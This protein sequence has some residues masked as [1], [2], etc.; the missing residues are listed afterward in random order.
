MAKIA[1][2]KFKLE[3]GSPLILTYNL[4]PNSLLP[5]WEK[6]VNDRKANE[7]NIPSTEFGKAPLELKIQ[8]KTTDHLPQLMLKLNSIIQGINEY[9]D[10]P[11]PLFTNINEID[12]HILNHLHE[13]FER[14][15]ERHG[16]IN[17]YVNYTLNPKVWPGVEFKRE[18]HQ[19]W[20][21]LNQWIHI[22]EAALSPSWFPN[23]SC[24]IQYT[25]FIEQG[26]P[27]D[28][29]DKMF[30]HTR[31]TWGSLYLGYNTLGKDYD[32][33]MNDNDQRVIA[34]DQIKVQ[35][36]LSSEVW[37][38]FAGEKVDALHKSEEYDFWVWYKSL[39]PELQAKVP[40]GNINALA[41]GRYYLGSISFDNEFL[42][43]HPKFEDWLEPNS[44]LRRRWNLEV[45]SKINKVIGI[46]I[47]DV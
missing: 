44:E 9:Y 30:L 31:F 41:L 12:H 6:V 36:F 46:K 33:T 21:D 39:S 5:K 25:P 38:N 8:N 14:Y 45:F 1:Q 11:L 32:H 40:I 16:A 15:G 7:F 22:T 13:E 26:A 35:Q 4:Q 43:F 47:L 20:L 28:E 17:N 23:F 37:L 3:D 24:L 29:E 42:K 27:I 2:F 10:C 34:N 19:L 18:F